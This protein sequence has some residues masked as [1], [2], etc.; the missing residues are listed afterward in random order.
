[1]LEAVRKSLESYLQKFTEA[2]HLLTKKFGYIEGSADTLISMLMDSNPEVSGAAD[3]MIKSVYS[4][5]GIH[6]GIRS[7]FQDLLVEAHDIVALCDEAQKAHT[8]ALESRKEFPVKS[9][10]KKLSK[11]AILDVLEK[12]E[13]ESKGD[14]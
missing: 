2:D 3:K 10:E 7:L 5:E 6:G 8:Q 4:L 13:E 1:M 11:G 9:P 14:K 12:L